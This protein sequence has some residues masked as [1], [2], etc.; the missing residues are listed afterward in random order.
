[1]IRRFAISIAMR[2]SMALRVSYPKVLRLTSKNLEPSF[3]LGED[4]DLQ[5][6]DNRN[7]SSCQIR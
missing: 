1:V 6:L 2:V 7:Q 4:Q 5:R 3:G